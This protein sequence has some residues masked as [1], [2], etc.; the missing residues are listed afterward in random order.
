MKPMTLLTLTFWLNTTPASA[1]L[2]LSP[3]MAVP[4]D[5]SCQPAE[6]KQHLHNDAS[7]IQFLNQVCP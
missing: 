2:I 6:L 4:P 3:A 7:F 5:S 1:Q